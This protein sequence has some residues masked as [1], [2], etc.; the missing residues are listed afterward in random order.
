[1]LRCFRR[2]RPRLFHICWR[3]REW[4][5]CEF[6]CYSHSLPHENSSRPILRSGSPPPRHEPR[7]F[8]SKREYL[9]ILLSLAVQYTHGQPL[10]PD[11][12]INPDGLPT[13]GQFA[14]GSCQGGGTTLKERLEALPSISEVEV[15]AIGDTET[16]AYDAEICGVNGVSC[17]DGVCAF[18]AAI[19]SIGGNPD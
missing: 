3:L 9:S 4:P 13:C 6:V 19:L 1:M 16:A 7:V 5:A 8:V 10:A 15:A 11:T 2:Q 14:E 17:K 18:P 12:V